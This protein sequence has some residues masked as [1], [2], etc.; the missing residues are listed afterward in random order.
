[1]SLEHKAEFS[2]SLAEMRADA[3]C[4]ERRM[5]AVLNSEM[6]AFAGRWGVPI[7]CIE[8]QVEC[9]STPDTREKRS[10]LRRFRVYCSLF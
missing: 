7:S 5:R 8:T 10:A 3:E 4:M 1:M 2:R 9:Y 6:E